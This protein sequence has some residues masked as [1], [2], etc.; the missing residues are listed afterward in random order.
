MKKPL[1]AGGAS[2]SFTHQNNRSFGGMTGGQLPKPGS[3]INPRK[4]EMFHTARLA[5]TLGI[6][7]ELD[8][9]RCRAIRADA[10]ESL[11]VLSAA[12]ADQLERGLQISVRRILRE[13]GDSVLL[14]PHRHAG[15]DPR[16]GF[17][18]IARGQRSA[19][20]RAFRL[21]PHHLLS[22]L[23]PQVALDGA[24][25]RSPSPLGRGSSAGVSCRGDTKLP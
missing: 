20:D 15:S 6:E 18:D 10:A 17:R 16:H 1:E 13:C 3:T 7:L 4:A 12:H 25:A 5:K 22:R 11:V 23:H 9:A 19:L 24:A 21:L 14:L 2:R 8:K